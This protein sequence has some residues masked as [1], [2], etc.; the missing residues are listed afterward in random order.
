MTIDLDL[1]AIVLNHLGVKNPVGPPEAG[2]VSFSIANRDAEIVLGV[3][4]QFTLVELSPDEARGLGS[5]LIAAAEQSERHIKKLNR[6]MPVAVIVRRAVTSWITR[7]R[8]GSRSHRQVQHKRKH[9][10]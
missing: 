3:S 4:R 7:A 5:K 2:G 1:Q 8:M 9:T 6:K 10:P